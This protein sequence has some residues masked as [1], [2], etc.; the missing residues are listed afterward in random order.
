M[1]EY[2][3]DRSWEPERRRLELQER[4]LDPITFDHLERVGVEPGW[5]VL[6]VGAGAGSIVQW[7]AGRVGAAGRVVALD[8]DTRLIDHLASEVVDVRA[9]DLLEADLDDGFDLVHCRMVLVH[10]ERKDEALDRLHAAVRPGGWLVVEE[11]DELY[12]LADG[13]PE[14]PEREPGVPPY[15]PALAKLW[16]EI[17]YDPWW[18]RGLLARFGRL[19][20]ES[21]GGEVRSPLVG[22]EAAE[23]ER[24]ML[25]RFRDRVLERG[26]ATEQQYSAWQ[27]AM[28]QPEWHAFLWFLTSVWGRKP[29]G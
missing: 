28:E 22:G 29:A 21:V 12:A 7:L 3:L 9:A 18:G 6:E 23:Q 4:T 5:R 10:V 1:A 24:L 2:I 17:G 25:A 16:S 14:W 13:S 8:L 27:R 26:Y 15:G 20:L 19:G 11:S